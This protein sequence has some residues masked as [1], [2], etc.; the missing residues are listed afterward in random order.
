MKGMPRSMPDMMARRADL[1][2]LRESS[3][4]LRKNVDAEVS[5]AEVQRAALKQPADLKLVYDKACARTV[6]DP[7][8]V[9]KETMPRVEDMLLSAEKLAIF[10]GEH[11]DAITFRGSVMEVRDPKPLAEANLLMTQVNE[12]SSEVMDAQRKMTSQVTGK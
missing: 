5:R 1:A 4:V 12:K 11:K 6:S 10:F 9:I 2:T 8:K 7:A 3:V